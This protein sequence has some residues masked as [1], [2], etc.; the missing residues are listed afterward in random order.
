MNNRSFKNP[1]TGLLVVLM[2]AIMV[3]L[4]SGC[5]LLE[6]S[7]GDPSWDRVLQSVRGTSVDLVVWDQDSEAL[8][9][10]EGAVKKRLSEVY[11]VELQ[12]K[13]VDRDDFIEGLRRS[14]KMLETIGEAD[15]LWLP[16][17][18]FGQL[19]SEGLLYGPFSSQVLNAKTYLDLEGLDYLYMDGVATDHFALPFNQ[20]Q[21]TFYYNEDMTFE[22]PTDLASLSTYLEDAQGTFTYPQPEDPVGRAFINSVILTYANPKDFVEKK[23]SDSE[24][25]ALVKPGLDYLRSLKPYLYQGGTSYPAS[26]EDLYDLFAKAQIFMVMSDNYRHANIMTGDALYPSGTRP[27]IF[28]AA[29]VGPKDYLS[30]PFYADN[31]SGAMVVMHAL[32]DL[33]I[34]TQKLASKQY[35]GLPVYDSAKLDSTTV[36]AIKKALNRKSIPEITKVMAQRVHDIPSQYDEKI[37]ALWR[38]IVIKP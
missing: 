30:I 25:R 33:E 19:K 35:Q 24:L 36:A 11:Q 4:L 18:S 12:V 10:F 23:L 9:W 13:K 7:S 27:V 17:K 28:G 34:Q 5:Q 21:L 3:V 26:A 6:E 1:W 37:A 2:S 32:L 16:A 8:A 20:Q 22:P 15:L 31:K 38:E 29:S 14:K